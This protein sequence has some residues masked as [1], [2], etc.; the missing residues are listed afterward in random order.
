MRGEKTDKKKYSLALAVFATVALAAANAYFSVLSTLVFVLTIFI[1]G[2]SVQ[3]HLLQVRHRKKRLG[4]LLACLSALYN[5]LALT[6][7]IIMID[8]KTVIWLFL[9]MVN[10][11]RNP[12]LGFAPSVLNGI[13]TV[14]CFVFLSWKVYHLETF[15]T[16]L[17][18]MMLF[19]AA[20]LAWIITRRLW[21][22]EQ[23]SVMDGLTGLRNRRSF[24][25]T[26]K[27]EIRQCLR[28]SRPIS[29]LMIDVDNFK[30]YND[31]LGHVKGDEILRRLAGIMTTNIRGNDLIFR[32]GGEEFCVLLP[33]VVPERAKKIAERIREEVETDFAGQEVPITVSIGISS[34]EGDGRDADYLLELADR[35]MYRAKVLKNRVVAT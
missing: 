26:L 1:A 22:F 16:V 13:V 24:N 25:A 34:S 5:P 35:A 20:V 17:G 30:R 2:I 27:Q 8:Y 7:L 19:A 6:A 23:Q 18:S 28:D 10:I 32:Y 29:L 21:L 14:V 15:E 31:T 33:G 11:L 3:I 12:Y 9:F 4:R